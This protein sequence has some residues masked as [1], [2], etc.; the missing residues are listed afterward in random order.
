[1]SPPGRPED[2]Y[3]R[4]Q[5]E[6]TSV[7]PPGRPQGEYRRAQHE[8]TPVTQPARSARR[9]RPGASQRRCPCA[10][11]G[12]TRSRRWLGAIACLGALAAACTPTPDPELAQWIAQQQAEA[13]QARARAVAT[14]ASAAAAT[15]AA[16]AAPCIG[17]AAAGCFQPA[18]AGERSPFDP[19][20]LPP[21]GRPG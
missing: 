1:M 9:C 14:A 5:H 12:R 11:P 7:T 20:R 13:R 17:D 10:Q 19:A 8:G 6:G 15:T 16:E 2:E 4:A 21:P 18:A 3:R